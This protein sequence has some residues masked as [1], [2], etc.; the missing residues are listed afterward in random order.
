MQIIPASDLDIVKQM[1]RSVG[2]PTEDIDHNTPAQFYLALM[3]G[4][5]VAL[6]GVECH[7]REALL[8]SLV[9]SPLSRGKG[10]GE[11]LIS[12]IQNIAREQ[13]AT[14]LYL[15]TTTAADYFRHLGFRDVRR[16]ETPASIRQTQEFSHLC[17]G[18][19]DILC[20]LI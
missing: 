13:G 3:D 8:R 6:A 2:L 17:P 9:V 15:L 4:T 7:G 10:I 20:R 1:L 12:H 14:T 5:V 18:D 11:A 16:E 19:A